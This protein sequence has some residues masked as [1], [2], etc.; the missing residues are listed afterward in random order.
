MFSKGSVTNQCFH[1]ALEEDN[2][3]IVEHFLKQRIQEI[4]NLFEKDNR[5]PLTLACSRKSLKSL[6]FLLSH[7]N[8]DV[9]KKDGMNMFP[10]MICV[11]NG[12]IEG[13]KELLRFEEI[14][15]HIED[16]V[17]VMDKVKRDRKLSSLLP[18]LQNVLEKQLRKNIPAPEV[19]P[20]QNKRM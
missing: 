16:R 5:T 3:A 1:E 12:F 9:N 10:L 11:E 15:L 2:F 18:L 17:N 14:N 13:A 6:S 8:I 19:S 4:N 7:H 20:P